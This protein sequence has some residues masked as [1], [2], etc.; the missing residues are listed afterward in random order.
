MR[1][2]IIDRVFDGLDVEWNLAL[3]C[4]WCHRT[5]PIFKPGEETGA[6][7]WFGLKRRISLDLPEDVASARGVRFLMLPAEAMRA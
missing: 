6:L 1:A 2:H 4:D 5:Q 7:A 3:L